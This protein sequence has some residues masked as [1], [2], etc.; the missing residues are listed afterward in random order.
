MI[1][2]EKQFG[3]NL[4]HNAVTQSN[5][6]QY[7]SKENLVP[8]DLVIFKSHP[9]DFEAYDITDILP[10]G[11]VFM[12]NGDGAYS[13]ISPKTIKLLQRKEEQL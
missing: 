5:Y 11:T 8:G 12:E 3:I 6:G 7:V 9:Y 1:K 10:D 4:P 2:Q 13:G